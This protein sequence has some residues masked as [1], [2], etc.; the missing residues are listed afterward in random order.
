MEITLADDIDWSIAAYV[1][2][3]FDNVVLRDGEYVL[4]P[5]R[6]ITLSDLWLDVM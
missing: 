1:E 3:S 2:I 6:H 4:A 5:D